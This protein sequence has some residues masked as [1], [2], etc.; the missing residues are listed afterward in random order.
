MRNYHI[1][2]LK[3]EQE[4]AWQTFVEGANGGTIFHRPDFLRYHGN[5]FSKNEHHL[6]WYKG[7]T[8]FGIMPM[9]V[10]EEEGRRI[11]RSPYGA[12]YGGSIFQKA[13]SYSESQRVVKSLL[14]YLVNA[15]VHECRLTL[16]IS[17]CYR[18]YSET[19]RLALLEHGFQCTNRD[20]SS[21]VPLD[22]QGSVLDSLSP[23]TRNIVRKAKQ[24]GVHIVENGSIH[25]LWQVLTK[26]YSKHGVH[27]THSLDELL[28]LH[29]NLPESV[30]VDLAYL[31]GLPVAGIAHFVINSRVD[32]SFYLCHDPEMRHA[33]S[34][35][36]L[37]H[38]ALE[39]ARQAGF[40]F[41]DLGTSSASMKGR[42]SI[43]KFKE[44]FGARGMF[45]D[46]Y[47]WRNNNGPT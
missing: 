43:F 44:G 22:F 5:R 16:P 34:L 32:S 24:H 40:L 45:R 38:S 39:H 3:P 30:Y 7:N 6:A 2:T 35:S 15:E 20:I 25:D 4:A 13:L 33:H 26:N 18:D 21:V 10:F 8:L 37:I 23:K 1:E 42:D 41:F 12:S 27:P 28:W 31:D 11:V 9:A 17:C 19:F 47:L 46:T 36:L 29:D 14:D